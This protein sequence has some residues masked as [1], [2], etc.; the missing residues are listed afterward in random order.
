MTELPHAVWEGTFTLGGFTIRCSVLDDGRRVINAEDLDAFF[1]GDYAE[2]LT[3]AEAQ[4]FA[5]W[6]RGGPQ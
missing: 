5:K 3:D 2:A 6:S 4:E 1:M